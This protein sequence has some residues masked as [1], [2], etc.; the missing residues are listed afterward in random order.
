MNKGKLKKNFFNPEALNRVHELKRKRMKTCL[1]EHSVQFMRCHPTSIISKGQTRFV[2]D[3]LDIY[4]D[5]PGGY[6]W[7]YS[8]ICKRQ[9]SVILDTFFQY[10]IKISSS[11]PQ[12]NKTILYSFHVDVP[13]GGW[14]ALMVGRLLSYRERE[15]RQQMGL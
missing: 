13:K 14:G 1:P 11:V 10:F 9:K 7:I 5:R 6:I 8:I 15:T 3:L 12:D 4:K 2:L